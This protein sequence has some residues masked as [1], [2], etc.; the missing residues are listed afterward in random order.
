MS[1]ERKPPIH[2]L[3]FSSEVRWLHIT[4]D[5]LTQKLFHLAQQKNYLCS[6]ELSQYTD[7]GITNR[8]QNLRLSCRKEYTFQY[9][10]I[11]EDLWMRIETGVENGRDERGQG[12]SVFSWEIIKTKQLQSFQFQFWCD[13]KPT[14]ALTKTQYS[15]STPFIWD[16][17]L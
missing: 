10:K 11:L 5:V 8:S 4:F 9:E 2:H 1:E 15:K 13:S 14:Q 6:S 7:L 3:H 17:A 12:H 16:R